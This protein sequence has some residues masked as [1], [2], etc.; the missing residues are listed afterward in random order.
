MHR[1]VLMAIGLSWP[2]FPATNTFLPEHLVE[3]ASFLFFHSEGSLWY[4][5][6]REDR[7]S[8]GVLACLDGPEHFITLEKL[9]KGVRPQM[10]QGECCDSVWKGGRGWKQLCL[11]AKHALLSRKWLSSQ[12]FI[13]GR[14]EFPFSFGSNSCWPVWPWTSYLTSLSLR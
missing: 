1:S 5:G 13:A 14:S 8:L 12:R 10:A 7:D 4:T 6:K 11:L 2:S 9:N 3:V